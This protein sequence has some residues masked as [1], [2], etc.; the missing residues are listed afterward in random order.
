M[1]HCRP[2]APSTRPLVGGA[3][4]RQSARTTND[5][6][7][8]NGRGWSS[9][10]TMTT[11]SLEYGMAGCWKGEIPRER[12]LSYHAGPSALLDVRS[13]VRQSLEQPLDFPALRQAFIPDDRIV[14]VLD[15]HVSSSPEIIAEVWNVCEA[16]GAT[17]D[18]VTILQPAALTGSRPA[19]PRRLL[20]EAV[21]NAM[22]W[23]I[24]DPTDPQSTGYLAASVS[25]ERIYLARDVLEADFLLP[26]SQLEF[27]PVQGRR[28]ATTSFYP[29]LSTTEAFAKSRGQGHSELGPDDE[30][31]LGQLI[32]EIGWLL[33][34][35]FAIQVLPSS[36]HS[37]AARILAGHSDSVDRQGRTLLDSEWRVQ[38]E[39]RGET[40]VVSI[41]AGS[42]ET[43][44]WEQLGAALEAASRLVMREGRIIVL[45]DM[46]G[47]PGP[48]I[49]MLRSVRSSKA[50][51]KPLR[52]ESPPDLLA[53]SQIAAA[54]DCAS[55]YLVSQLSPSLVEDCFMTPL[56]DEIEVTRLLANCDGC[57]VIAGAQHA[58][59]EIAD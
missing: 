42:G 43:T 32:Q 53:A 3:T 11:I 21:R 51:L 18:R 46:T 1:P 25:G 19:D 28:S 30:R 23:K 41:P 57:I 36:S 59:A 48:G 34:I 14:V 49:E 29:G 33:G 35:Q 17:P 4:S 45:S 26:I 22:P 8:I 31:P 56:K 55:V 58:Y 12:L 10:T 37:G 54:A 50:A 52:K 7:R 6:F 15:R 2:V 40:V 16:G 39:Q 13:A 24:H 47:D 9:E 44:G 27:D 5:I 38:A 20:P